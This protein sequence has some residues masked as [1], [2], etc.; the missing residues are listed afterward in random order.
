NPLR[1]EPDPR[2]RARTRRGRAPRA[3]RRAGRSSPFSLRMPGR[4]LVVRSR[5]EPRGWWRALRTARSCF[6]HPWRARGARRDLVFRDADVSINPWL[7]WL[8]QRRPN[9]DEAGQSSFRTALGSLGAQLA[10]PRAERAEI[11]RKTA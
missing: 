9:G 6:R 10:V 2:G 11:P 4:R 3:P 8:L 1:L 5:R 7:S